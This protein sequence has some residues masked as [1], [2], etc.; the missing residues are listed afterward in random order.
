MDKRKLVAEVARKSD[1][2]VWEVNKIIEP[3]LETILT[4]LENGE[5]VSLNNFGKFKLKHTK[6]KTIKHVRTKQSAKVPEKA[7]IVFSQTRMFKPT[8]ETMA[9]LADQYQQKRKK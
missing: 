6:S 5:E 3:L 8:K 4:A 1:Y 2:A 7:T 9:E